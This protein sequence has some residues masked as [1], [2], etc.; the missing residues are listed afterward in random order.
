MQ[1]HP[2]TSLLPERDRQQGGRAGAVQVILEG[3]ELG[4]TLQAGAESDV[5][6]YPKPGSSLELDLTTVI[7]SDENSSQLIVL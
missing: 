6:A 4:G 2:G 7:L 3:R 5:A 1:V